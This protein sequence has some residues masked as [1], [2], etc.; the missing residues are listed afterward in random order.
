MV[1]I[2]NARP[3]V[4]VLMFGCAYHVRKSWL[5]VVCGDAL[6][7]SWP[8]CDIRAQMSVFCFCQNAMLHVAGYIGSYGV[9]V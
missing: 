7:C 9:W 1:R 5:L 8:M 4:T 2:V 6:Q 3:Y